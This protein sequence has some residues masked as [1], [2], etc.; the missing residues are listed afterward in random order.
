MI[1]RPIPL[2]AFVVK[3]LLHPETCG[4]AIEEAE[5]G[6]VVLL[7]GPCW[8]LDDRGSAVE[9]LAAAVQHELVVRGDFGE[10]DRH[11]EC[12]AYPIMLSTRTT[13]F[14]CLSGV[15]P[16]ID[17]DFGRRS[18]EY[19]QSTCDR[20]S[21]SVNRSLEV[22]GCVYGKTTMRRTEVSPVPNV[23]PDGE[24]LLRV[25]VSEVPARWSE[26]KASS[27]PTIAM[28]PIDSY[29]SPSVMSQRSSSCSFS[30]AAPPPPI[31]HGCLWKS[32]R[33]ESLTLTNSLCEPGWS[34]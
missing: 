27:S 22:P 1:P 11:A 13:G 17:R 18:F 30:S 4:R 8:Q 15:F 16:N 2:L 21:H 23:F 3:H 14:R 34:I 29:S 10:G 19:G 7:G 31:D 24:R 20:P 25:G 12:E 5:Q 28:N 9:Y 33:G 26:M 6:E 32:P